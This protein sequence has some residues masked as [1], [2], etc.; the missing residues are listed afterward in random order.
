VVGAAKA[1]WRSSLEMATA[2]RLVA[3]RSA[4]WSP[5]C[6][7]AAWASAF[8][9]S[10]AYGRLNG[11]VRFVHAWRSYA[12]R[13]VMYSIWCTVGTLMCTSAVGLKPVPPPLGPQA[14][15][16]LRLGWG[17]SGARP[18]I[19]PLGREPV[20][21][22]AVSCSWMCNRASST[23]VRHAAAPGYQHTLRH[24]GYG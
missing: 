11:C 10:T 19:P 9:R 16:L 7:L 21:L 22:G 14:K 18:S 23:P 15:G 17:C 4:A 8:T 3:R 6:L 2:G 20:Q 5:G 1:A 12:A 13:K 24:Y